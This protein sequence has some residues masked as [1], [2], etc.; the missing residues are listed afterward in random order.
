MMAR[1]EAGALEDDIRFGLGA[2]LETG[3][4]AGIAV[5]DQM[6]ERARMRG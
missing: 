5:R 3:I 1:T 4:E 2:T 6:R